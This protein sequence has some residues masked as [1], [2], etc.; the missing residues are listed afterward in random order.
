MLKC[1]AYCPALCIAAA[2][3]HMD[4]GALR[5]LMRAWRDSVGHS[6]SHNNE[7][8]KRFRPA[9]PAWLVLVPAPA[10]LGSTTGGLEFATHRSA[11]LA[12]RRSAMLARASCGARSMATATD[13]LSAVRA[14]RLSTASE[15]VPKSGA[16]APPKS[17]HAVR[18]Q[19]NGRPLHARARVG[20]G[21]RAGATLAT[22]PAH[23]R[24]A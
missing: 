18:S 4:Q 19:N 9:S 3:P 21:A 24:P 14:A 8:K 6:A 15:R 22:L 13:L 11:M 2:N 7:K 1:A 20:A 17:T 16:A 12:A 23:R 10:D 5:T